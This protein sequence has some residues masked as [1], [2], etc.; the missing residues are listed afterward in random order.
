MIPKSY[1][2]IS[3]SVCVYNDSALATWSRGSVLAKFAVF[4]SH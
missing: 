2:H 3:Y 1:Q 4:L